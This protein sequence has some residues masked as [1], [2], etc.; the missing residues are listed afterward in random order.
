[1]KERRGVQLSMT[2]RGEVWLMYMCMGQK[3]VSIIL[4][5]SVGFHH[6]CLIKVVLKSPYQLDTSDVP[7]AKPEQP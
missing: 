1:L 3:L 5:A 6:P 7:V 4:L 2:V